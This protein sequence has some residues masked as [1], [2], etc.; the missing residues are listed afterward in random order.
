MRFGG[1]FLGA[2]SFAGLATLSDSLS[3]WSMTSK[4]YFFPTGS[5]VRYS[6]VTFLL[7]G[8]IAVVISSLILRYGGPFASKSAFQYMRSERVLHHN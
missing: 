1:F 6:V 8:L 7:F 2:D 4:P 3:R 5:S